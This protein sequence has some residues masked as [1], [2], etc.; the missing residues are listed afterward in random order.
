VGDLGA[1]HEAFRQYHKLTGRPSWFL[2][3]VDR[4]YERDGFKGH[5][6][7]LLTAIREHDDGSISHEVRANIACMGDQPEEAL[8]ELN[9]ALRQRD[10]LVFMIGTWPMVDCVRSDPRFQELLR[11][12]N[13]PG[14][15][16]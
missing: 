5:M 12:I 15:E 14:L 10:P 8:V 9:H 13:W 4:G 11:K 3:A 6:R 1:A 16:E 2:E 7:E